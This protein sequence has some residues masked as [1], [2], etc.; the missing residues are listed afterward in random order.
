MSS[1]PVNQAI[2]SQFLGDQRNGQFRRSQEVG[3]TE[4]HIRLLQDKKRVELLEST[5]V[6]WTV[7]RVDPNILDRLLE[8]ADKAEKEIAILDAMLKLGASSQMIADIFG[9]NQ[10]DIAFRKRVLEI[11][12]KQGRWQEVTE[13]QNHE[14][15]HK[16]KA[17]IAQYQLD[18]ENLTDMAKV[19]M[20]LAKNSGIP[21]AMIWSAMRK[22]M[23]DEQEQLSK[24]EQDAQQQVLLQDDEA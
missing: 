14:L 19:C 12:K 5:P 3:F 20:I 2:L 16:W 11:D 4:K 18:I 8:C 9:Y 7:V 21:M 15:W 22:W 13:E 10:R 6:R 1:Q 24:K 17:K 23:E